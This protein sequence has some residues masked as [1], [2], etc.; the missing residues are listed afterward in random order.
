MRKLLTALL[1]S[2]LLA[3]QPVWADPATPVPV[4]MRQPDGSYITLRIH[5]DE[6]YRWYSSEDDKTLYVCDENGWWKAAGPVH[7]NKK[8]L[9]KA[10]AKKKE[11]RQT[12]ASSSIAFG[13]RRFLVIMVQWS[14]KKFSSGAIDY[15]KRAVNGSNFHDYNAEGSAREYYEAS[16]SGQFLPSFDVLG[17]VTISRKSKEYPEGDDDAHSLMAS[18]SISEALRA[19]DSSVDFSQYDVNKDG[20][21]DNI[22]MFYPGYSQSTG[23]GPETI[24]PHQSTLDEEV[25]VDGVK[26]SRYACSSELRGAEGTIF[27][28]GIGSFC[29]EFGHVLG[30]PDFYDIDYEE[31]GTADYPYKWNL[32]ASGSHLLDGYVPPS[33]S[34]YERYLL[35]YLTE[36]V[37]LTPGDH[38]IPAVSSNKM[39]RI[40]AA[41]PGEFFIP[42][43]RTG[44]HW[45]RG[46]AAGLILYHVDAS[47]NWAGNRTAAQ[48]WQYETINCFAEHPC[49]YLMTPEPSLM[50]YGRYSILDPVYKPTLS[51]YLVF[52]QPDPNHNPYDAYYNVN[53]FTLSD[54]NGTDVYNLGGIR[55]DT[56]SEKASFR[57]QIASRQL[58]G[59]VTDNKGNPIPNAT[60]FVN[61]PPAVSPSRM[62]TL[63]KA[64]L[65]SSS[66]AQVKTDVNGT[67]NIT[68]DASW[69]Q[70][71][72]VAAFADEYI[73][74][75]KV[76]EGQSSSK[77]DFALSSLYTGGE[78]VSY[79]RTKFP[80][81]SVS[82]WGFDE[83]GRNYTVA[84][85]YTADELASHAGGEITS[86]SFSAYATG[87]EVWVFV[88]KGTSERVAVQKV[89]S[90]ES[91][92]WADQFANTVKLDQPFVLKPDTDYYIGYMVKNADKT[93]VMFTDHEKASRGGLCVYYDFSTTTPGGSQWKEP[94]YDSGWNCGNALIGYTLKD[95]PRIDGSAKL[96]DMG[97]SYIQLPYGT[98]TAGDILNLKVVSSMAKPYDQIVWS[99]DGQTVTGT[100][101]TLT[102]GEHTLEAHLIYESAFGGKDEYLQV[103]INVL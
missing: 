80:M 99:L 5:G 50:I 96:T 44:K 77:I 18:V 11:R 2:L 43:V 33:L 68:L 54:W 89:E 87:E 83:T 29:H 4:R 67:Y 65:M 62:K 8:T 60:I 71:L 31:N 26:A 23:G 45:D 9:Q 84:L 64:S 88:D 102:A 1:F 32:M 36:I 27:F 20:Y 22:Y 61:R 51:D 85:H 24:W 3:L 37:N 46:L 78:E 49:Y 21:V 94:A 70:E 35:G 19:L 53:T 97:Y 74:S 42:E 6:F 48:Q 82:R 100:S 93:Y 39:Y 79:S 72:S 59:R 34:S 13:E 28:S 16:S 75:E 90:P 52:P 103:S 63:S 73:P 95:I 56:S 15:F 41:A 25:T 57:M 38:V 12:I 7:H 91:V 55:Y 92:S 40:P 58:L 69:P 98:L 81:E 86:I 47:D 66:L 14:D 10:S 30:L 17:P 76:Y 101:V